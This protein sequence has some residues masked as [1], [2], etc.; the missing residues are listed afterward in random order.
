MADDFHLL[1][2]DELCFQFAAFDAI[3]NILHGAADTK[4]KGMAGHRSWAISS[5]D[6][7]SNVGSVKSE[8]IKSISPRSSAAT[9]PACVCTR[10]VVQWMSPASMM[11]W[12]STAS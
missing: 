4:I 5:A 8:R 9:K 2:L 6:N 3:F 7:P 10:V 1:R 12:I 11:D